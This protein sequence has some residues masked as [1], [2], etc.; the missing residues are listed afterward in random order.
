MFKKYVDNLDCINLARDRELVA[1]C[2]EHGNGPSGNIKCGKFLDY[3]TD[4]L[5]KKE[6]ALCS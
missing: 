4:Q 1:G 5:L 6:S 3:L 2:Y